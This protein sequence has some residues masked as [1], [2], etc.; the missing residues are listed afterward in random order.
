MRKVAFV[1]VLFALVTAGAVASLAVR[2]TAAVDTPRRHM[3]PRVVPI[4]HTGLLQRDFKTGQDVTRACLGCHPDAARQV[5]RTSHWSWAGQRVKLPGRE[6]ALKVGK[7]NLLNNFC[8]HAGPNIKMCSSCHAG[9]GWEDNS[10]DFTAEENVDC[11]ICHDQSNGYRKGLA[12]NPE[13]GVDLLAVAES[14]GRPTRVNCGQCHF[15]GG[16]GDA[17]K[18]GDMDGSMYF[19]TQ[20]IDMHM[21]KHDFQCVDC[22]RTT[23]HQIP[24]CAMSVCMDRPDRVLCIDCHSRQ[25]HGRERLDFHTKTVACQT[26]HI[27]RMAIDAP[28]KMFSDMSHSANGD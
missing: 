28:T 21:G 7:L 17:V 6:E 1:V 24:G 3:P 23:D 19:P 20:R 16:G 26:C 15:K 27:P 5:M 18:H 12:G 9:Y 25:P 8:M 11:L 14:V 13:P 10:F 2:T 22:H 4:D